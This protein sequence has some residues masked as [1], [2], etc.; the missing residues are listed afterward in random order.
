MASEEDVTSQPTKPS[1]R[2]RDMRIIRRHLLGYL[3]GFTIFLVAIPAGLHL[4]SAELDRYV[5]VHLIPYAPVRVALALLF[6]IIGLGFVLISN[7][8]LLVVGRGGPADGFGVQISPRSQRLVTSGPYR[9]T[10]NPMMFGALTFYL[11]IAIYLNS[12][13]CLAA[14]A[15]L[16]VLGP[17]YLKRVEEKRL[18]RDFGEAY[19]QY[20]RRVSLLVP[21]PPRRSN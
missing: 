17:I 8:W 21:W 15:T 13:V 2:K 11:G 16:F 3:F 6:V 4:L 19:E 9:Y 12:L 10:R 20:R 18:L 1:V 5:P 7:I 14:V